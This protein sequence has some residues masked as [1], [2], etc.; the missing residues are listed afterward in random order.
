LPGTRA[1]SGIRLHVDDAIFSRWVTLSG[2]NADAYTQS[3][4]IERAMVG[5]VRIDETAFLDIPAGAVTDQIVIE[6]AEGRDQPLSIRGATVYSVGALL[7]TPDAGPAPQTLYFGGTEPDSGSD[8]AIAADELARIAT[9][10]PA[11]APALVGVPN[12]S[13]VPRATREGL[14]APGQALNLALWPWERVIDGAA[15]WVRVTVGSGDLV[16]A[17]GDRGDLRVVD[18]AGRS[19]PYQLRRDVREVELKLGEPVRTERGSDSELL[20]PLPADTGMVRRIELRTDQA[21]FSR[22]VELLRD[23]GSMTEALRSVSWTSSGSP[24]PLSLDVHD[25]LGAALLIRIQNGDDAPLPVTAVRAWSEES[26]LLFRMPD[27][28][29]RL[30]Y[31]N[32]RASE[33]DFDVS[34]VMASRGRAPIAS[35]A[36]GAEQHAVG[37]PMSSFDVALVYIAFGGLAI[38]LV[39]LAIGGLRGSPVPDSAPDEK[40]KGAASVAAPL[41][42]A[43]PSASSQPKD[44]TP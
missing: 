41:A 43:P 6:V 30:I 1:L 26:E 5:D 28:G 9:K 27:G 14:D 20:I 19:V 42:S 40:P 25:D 37:V 18:S 21:V 15:G 29:A 34:M 8:I 13:F 7:V 33:P 17:R 3:F 23:R 39:A 16:H 44:P 12:P 4:Q 31:G 2:L 22:T 36:L 10:V 35:A 32:R 11:D 24:A 38:G